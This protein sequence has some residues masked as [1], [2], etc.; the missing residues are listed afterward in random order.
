MDSV[1]PQFSLKHSLLVLGRSLGSGAFGSVQEARWGNQP[2][3]AKTFFLSQ[4]DLDLQSIQREISVLQKLRFRHII[5]FY[6]THEEHGRIHLLMELAEKGSL[7][8]AINRKEIGLDD[9]VTKRRLAS[10]IAQGL[11]FIHQE[12]VLHRDLKSANVLL[13]RHMEVKLADFGLAKVKSMTMAA[14]R[15]SQS[16]VGLAGTLR[17]IA[18]ELLFAKKPEYTTKSDV[19][20]LGVVLWEM[21][22]HCTRPFADQDND[23][24]VA[25][26]VSQ[27]DRETFPVNTPT[28][29]RDWAERCWSQ[30]PENRPDASE[31]ALI[32]GELVE[33]NGDAGGEG[34]DRSFV[35]LS[36][37]DADLTYGL[38][39][40]S[41]GKQGGIIRKKTFYDDADQLHHIGRLPS[42]DDD[43]VVAHMCKAAKQGIVEGQLFL[44]WIYDHGRGVDKSE[45][46]AFWWYR[47]AASQGPVVAQLRVAKMYELG[48]GV[49][50][51][52]AKAASWYQRAADGGSAEAQ[53]RIGSMYAEGLVVKYDEEEA[54]KWYLSAAN[55]GQ[56]DA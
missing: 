55:Q 8:H 4:S 3:A 13:T 16:K 43:E 19:Y 29:Y 18:P 37:T 11:A 21:A 36:I 31:V 44:G 22:A 33:A 12:K 28:E 38:M 53:Y 45:K 40:Q 39:L 7:A 2:C 30:D 23:A 1:Q 41:G 35:D 46:D 42:T 6:R 25:L 47:L 5:Q 34:D 24:F 27:G 9:W 50:K 15:A 52:H 14:T 49:D 56:I 17:W 54:L 26:A 51:S 48:Q 32:A 20:A 10:E